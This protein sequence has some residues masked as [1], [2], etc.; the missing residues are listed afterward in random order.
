MAILCQSSSPA[1]SGAT[2]IWGLAAHLWMVGNRYF[3]DCFRVAR[4]RT[5][6]CSQSVIR[7]V[8]CYDQ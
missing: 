5:G 3:G 2:L 1:C 4:L 6:I 7:V 8:A